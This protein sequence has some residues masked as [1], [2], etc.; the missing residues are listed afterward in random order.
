M[1]IRIIIVGKTKIDYLREGENDYLGRLRRDCQIE[2]REIKEELIK[3]DDERKIKEIEGE[4]II[5]RLDKDYFNIAL[6]KE[7]KIFDSEGFARLIEEKKDYAGAKICFIIGGPL[8]L[9][10]KVLERVNLVLSF[11]RMTFTHELIRLM[12]LEQIYRAFEILRGSKYHK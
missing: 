1:K 8:G 11:S 12:L 2:F 4:R 3:D 5:E 7:G 10:K 9:S 6:D